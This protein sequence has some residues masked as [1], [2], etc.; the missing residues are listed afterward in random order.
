MEQIINFGITGC[1]F[2]D[3]FD[4]EKYVALACQQPRGLLLQRQVELNWREWCKI[5]AIAPWLRYWRRSNAIK[6]QCVTPADL[7]CLEHGCG[8]V[9]LA[10]YS[11][12]VWG[13][14]LEGWLKPNKSTIHDAVK[15]LNRLQNVHTSTSHRSRTFMWDAKL[16]RECGLMIPPEL[17][18]LDRWLEPMWQEALSEVAVSKTRD[19]SPAPTAY[20]QFKK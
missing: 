14:G 3:H 9:P 4:A 18:D 19:V 2:Q 13:F 20:E 7:R 8:N 6:E 16:Y 1:E 17:G 10:I 15:A 11:A 12:A 5:V